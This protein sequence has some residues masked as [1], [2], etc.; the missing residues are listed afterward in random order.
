MGLMKPMHIVAGIAG[1]ALLII[2]LW[3]TLETVILPRS[4]LSRVRLTIL[5]NRATWRLWRLVA[6]KCGPR[7]E[8]IL[9]M[10][11]PLFLVILLETWAAGLVLGFA[12]LHWAAGSHIEAAAGAAR[13]PFDLY[14]S[15]TTFFTLGLGDLAPRTMLER[16]LTVVEA[17]MGLGFL[18]IVIGYFPVLYAGFSRR[19]ATISLMDARAGSPPTAGELLIRSARN[20]DAAGIPALLRDFEQWSAELLESHLSYPMLA[21][22]RSQ[23]DRESW[24]SALTMV[25][26]ASALVIAGVGD[27]PEWQG[28]LT[29]AMARHAAVDLALIFDTPPVDPPADRLPPREYDRLAAALA[30][31]GLPPRDGEA[32]RALADLRAL[33]EPYVHALSRYLV[34]AVPPWLPAKVEEDN[35]QTTAWKTVRHF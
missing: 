25:L 19:E 33:Y 13:F 20:G 7:R 15:G 34:L 17:N 22:Y 14:F 12:L 11:G 26:D 18:A 3:D 9:G 24:L 29:F 16:T 10:Y 30:G 31:A 32:A 23:H 8:R 6:G 4:V 21:F 5:L 35:W 27:V 28:R 1:V 2:V